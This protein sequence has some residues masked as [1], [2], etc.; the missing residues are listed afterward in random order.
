MALS[1]TAGGHVVA[2]FSLFHL[3]CILLLACSLFSRCAEAVDSWK[4]YWCSVNIKKK[5]SQYQSQEAVQITA[6][7]L[8][9][10]TCLLSQNVWE[11]LHS[12][13]Y[14]IDPISKTLK[15]KSRLLDIRQNGVWQDVQLYFPIA[16]IQPRDFNF[17]WAQRGLM[18][19]R[20]TVLL[21]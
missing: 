4:T 15:S 20:R 5:K 9:T 11:N 18:H 12:L 1:V 17:C 19:C 13:V 8:P 14:A 7:A 2:V 3:S 6:T 16:M 10:D 21:N